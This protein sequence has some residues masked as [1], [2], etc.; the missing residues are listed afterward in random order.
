MRIVLPAKEGDS[1]KG[2]HFGLYFLKDLCCY[3]EKT[4][5]T[6]QGFQDPFQSYHS[7]TF[8]HGRSVTKCNVWWSISGY[9]YA[10]VV[11]FIPLTWEICNVYTVAEQIDSWLMLYNLCSRF[12]IISTVGSHSWQL[13]GI[14]S[15]AEI[16]DVEWDLPTH[17]L[18][19][20]LYSQRPSPPLHPFYRWGHWDC[21]QFSDLP[22]V[23]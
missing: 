9:L 22:K 6:C 14:F 18:W 13:K 20:C 4:A 7:A 10:I 15:Y 23:T 21:Q 8:G 16:Y 2:R 5:I 19:C 17:S 12:H 11:V 3:S 1:A